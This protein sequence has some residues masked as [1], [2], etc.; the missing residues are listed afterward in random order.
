MIDDLTLSGG[1]SPVKLTEKL[2]AAFQKAKSLADTGEKITGNRMAEEY[3][4]FVAANVADQI[5][6]IAIKAGVLGEKEAASYINTFVNRTQGNIMASQRPLIFQGPIGQAVGLFQGFQFNTMQQLFRA[7]S[8]GSAKDAAMM[9]GLQGTLYGL[10]G[11]P[12]FQYINQQIYILQPMAH[13]EKKPV[14][15]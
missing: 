12:G 8:E 15:G 3:N 6:Q 4:R 10:N 13:L 14:T 2:D 11:L 9:L 1:E 5:T 7:V